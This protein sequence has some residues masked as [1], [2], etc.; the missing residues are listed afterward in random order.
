MVHVE[1]DRMIKFPYLIQRLSRNGR[2]P[3]TVLRDNR[4][5]KQDL[6]VEPYSPRLFQ[7]LAEKPPS[8]FVFGPLVFTDVTINYISSVTSYVAPFDDSSSYSFPSLLYSGNPMY[9]RYG[10][11]PAFPDERIVIIA[12]PMFTHK[13]SKG[14][15]VSY[16]AAVAEVN[17]V[18]IRNLKHMVEVIRGATGEFIEFTFQGKTTDAIVFYRKEAL[19]ATEEILNDNGIRHQ[20]SP[21]IAPVWNQAKAK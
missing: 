20:C 19:E 6:P 18:R 2:L 4:G 16:S 12:Y 21:D 5:V 8:Y 9:T 13:I 15:D 7:S 17:G 1:G 10:D 14:Y 3:V 11:R